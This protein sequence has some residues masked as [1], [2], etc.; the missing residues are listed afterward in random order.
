MMKITILKHHHLGKKSPSEP[1]KQIQVDHCV[2]EETNNK[3]SATSSHDGGIGHAEICLQLADGKKIGTLNESK[4][5]YSS[6]PKNPWD[7]I[8]G[9]FFPPDV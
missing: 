6:H 8:G 5:G 7:V 4:W 3:K 2:I 1:Y 9:F